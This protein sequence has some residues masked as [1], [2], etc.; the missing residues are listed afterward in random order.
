MSND[1]EPRWS[2]DAARHPYRR[3]GT[4]PTLVQSAVLFSDVLGTEE[5][6]T[7]DEAEAYLQR[8]SEALARAAETAGV[9]DV[10]MPHGVSWFSDNLAVGW[11]L[12]WSTD[13]E[14]ALGGLELAAGYLQASLAE[15]GLL[16]RGGLTFGPHYMDETIVFGPALVEAVRL[17]REKAIFPRV[18]LGDSAVKAEDHHIDYYGRGPHAPQRTLLLVDD[19]GMVFV[20]YLDVVMED[21][22][23]LDASVAYL[24][25]HRQVAIDGLRAHASDE[26]KLSK[27]TWLAE[28]HNHFCQERLPEMPELLVSQVDTSRGFSDFGGPIT[29]PPEW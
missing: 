11:P 29:P 12:R 26:R 21:P 4:T 20:N 1:E 25:A 15:D 16:M 28:Y 13:S 9:S 3:S 23:R 22:D 17:E 24:T 27:Y 6:A 8:S 10:D 14:I 2:L 19:D 5:M 7:S 18:V